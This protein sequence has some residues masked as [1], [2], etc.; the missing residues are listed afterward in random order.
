VRADYGGGASSLHMRMHP[1]LRSGRRLHAE[2]LDNDAVSPVP[3]SRDMWGLDRLEYLRPSIG[4]TNVRAVTRARIHCASPLYDGNTAS[5]EAS[6]R[7]AV[8]ARKRLL[9]DAP[10]QFVPPTTTPMR[11]PRGV[12]ETHR[13]ADDEL[14]VRLVGCAEPRRHPALLSWPLSC[15]GSILFSCWI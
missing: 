7:T 6:F 4:G 15:F 14:A 2:V 10:R 1:G 5:C 12:G 13:R 9:T 11:S 3:V 8:S